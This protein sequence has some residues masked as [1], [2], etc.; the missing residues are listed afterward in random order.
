MAL[1]NDEQAQFGQTNRSGVRLETR[2]AIDTLECRLSAR[3]T[4]VVTAYLTDDSGAVLERQTIASLEAG[5][6]FEFETGLEADEN[7]WI[8]CDAHGREYVRGRAAVDY[9]LE[10]D[11]L[12]VTHGI[13][14]GGGSRS[15]TYRY[16]IDRIRTGTTTSDIG[17]VLDLERDGEAQ[18][19]SGLS[20]RSGVRLN[21]TETISGLECRVSTETAGLT[22]AYLTDDSG[23]VID[24]QSIDDLEAGETFV[25]D[26]P[27]EAGETYWVV[28][29]A[30]GQRY[31]RGR[32]AVDYPLESDVLEATHGIFAGDGAR[33]EN[34]RYCIDRIQPADSSIPIGA[35][36]ALGSDEQGQSWSSLTEPSGVRLETTEAA[37]GLECR[38]S[39][40]TSG[41]TTAYLTTDDGVVLERQTIAALGAGDA[42]TFDTALEAG[43]AYRVLCGARGQRYTRGR[44]P[45]DYPL[46]S[47]SL[48]ATHGVFSGTEL[49]NSYRYCFDRIRPT[50]S[51]QGDVDYVGRAGSPLG[52]ESDDQGQSWSSLTEPSGV[53]LEANED[54]I[55]LECRLSTETDGVTTAY[56]TDDSGAVLDQQSIDD[57]EA[58]DVVEFD[59]ELVADE[60]YRILCDADGQRYVRGRA[61]VD[62]PL[63]SDSLTATHG[64]FSGTELSNSYRYCFDWVRPDVVDPV[65]IG[66]A[67]SDG[68]LLDLG[69]DEQGQSWSSLTEPSGVRIHATEAVDGLECRISAATEGITTAFLTDDA[70]TVLDQRS[71][72]NL[73]AGDV[74]ELD[75]ELEADETYRILCDADGQRYV[76]GRAAVDYPI[77]SDSLIATHGVFSGAALSSSYRYCIDRIQPAGSNRG[78]TTAL[79][80]R[81]TDV[82]IVNVVDHPSIDADGD[83]SAEILA[84]LEAQDETNHAFVLPT[85]T[86]TWN[87]EFDLDGP[88]EYFEISGDPRATLQVRDHDV[89]LAFLFGRWGNTNPPRHVVLRNL[90]VDIDDQPERDAGLLIAHVDRCLIDNVE[91]VGQRWRHGPEGGD[92]YTCMLNT[93]DEALLSI[94]RNLSLPDGDL[95]DSSLSSVGH[96]IG[97]SADPPHNGL[98]I[99]AQCYV[100]EFVDNGLYVRNSPGD[101]IVTH[102]MA[103]NCGNGNIRLGEADESRD[104]RIRLD[105]GANQA[106]PGAGLWLNGGQP[107]AERTAIDGSDA[108]NDIVRVNSGADGGHIRGLRVFCGPE[109][110]APT[111]RCTYTSET[112]LQGVLIEDFEIHDI[113]EASNHPS[114]RIRRPDVTLRDGVLDVP[115]RPALGG[116]E[117]PE[118]DNVEIR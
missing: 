42:F 21:A 34:Y 112:D 55:G 98:N 113:S 110:R 85:G 104:C 103:V 96:S 48:T 25:L 20:N 108:G 58:G 107:I 40:E 27:L 30:G 116:S 70:G 10:S 94:V 52:L 91:L 51:G 3:T 54:V 62:Y 68:P 37:D 32:A 71:L 78:L 61:A 23:A 5:D 49:S 26:T 105:E 57:L 43:T 76:R 47:D 12:A 6:T 101:N 88:H 59:A 66:N 84:Y 56:L 109:V 29:D 17:A 38:L 117:Q 64:I 2:T 39:T 31:T 106:H 75:A 63:E 24:Q 74:F 7:Y 45:V 95:E 15:N 86:Y 22:T 69:S 44:T 33:T 114:V 18:S 67:T 97:I 115:N 65:W 90:D 9:P 81:P 4:G 14:T 16:C 72:E 83:L 77:A 19:W 28:C 100:E 89:D 80:T 92:R 118:L 60:T 102:S 8:L 11:S 13:F 53:R 46:E 111:V 73:A 1:E 79:E 50:A 36:L 35:T 41:I 82:T 99:W 93:R 87:T